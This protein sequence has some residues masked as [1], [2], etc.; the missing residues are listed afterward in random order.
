MKWFVY[1]N[2]QYYPYA[3]IIEAETAEAALE[4][5]KSLYESR[6]GD[7]RH[8]AAVFPLDALALDV[9]GCIAR[10]EDSR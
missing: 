2:E 1:D 4:P 9:N 6:H 7:F 8:G 3:E 5:L 10:L